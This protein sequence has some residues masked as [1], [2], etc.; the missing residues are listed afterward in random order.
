[1]TDPRVETRPRDPLRFHPAPQCPRAQARKKFHTR[2]GPAA[3]T[4]D[5][6]DPLTVISARLPEQNSTKGST[7][8]VNPQYTADGQGLRGAPLALGALSSGRAR[9]VRHVV[10][11]VVVDLASRRLPDV[12]IMTI[13]YTG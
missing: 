2:C 8:Q 1:L 4:S 5:N 6:G 11:V 12:A 7:F 3:Q 13:P 10:V 9:Q